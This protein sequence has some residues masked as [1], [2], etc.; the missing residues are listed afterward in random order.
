MAR[1][2]YE[3]LDNKMKSNVWSNKMGFLV[4]AY[5]C[6]FVKFVQKYIDILYILHI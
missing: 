3:K 2:I 6:I 5:V 4:F 1:A